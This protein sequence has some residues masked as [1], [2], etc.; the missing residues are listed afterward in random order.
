MFSQTTTSYDPIHS[1]KGFYK[2]EKSELDFRIDK[3]VCFNHH[4]VIANFF[5]NAI[6]TRSLS[7][8]QISHDHSSSKPKGFI[9][10]K[11]TLEDYQDIDNIL[12]AFR[13]WQDRNYFHPKLL[14]AHGFN[15]KGEPI[16]ATWE[17]QNR[18]QS[19]RNIKPLSEAL[20][21]YKGK[22]VFLTLTVD[23]SRS[24]QDAWQ[25][26]AQRWHI[27]M[28]RL[29]LEIRSAP[30]HKDFK[31]SDLHYIWVL[32]A[33]GNGYPHIHALFLGIDWLFWAGNK[34]A[35]IEDNPHSKNLKH[36]WKWGSV[37]INSTKKGENV[38]N[39]V[40]Y[41]MKYIRKTFDPYSGDSKKELTQAMLWC[42]NKRSWNTSR[43][44]FEYLKY[45]KPEP[46]IDMDLIS[47]DN[48]ERL[49]GQSTPYIRLVTETPSPSENSITSYSINDLDYLSTIG[50]PS[51]QESKAIQ[52]LVGMI[53]H[54][55]HEP[56]DE[57]R[58]YIRP[59]SPSWK[60]HRKKRKPGS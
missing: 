52:F 9:E 57:F 58:Y 4:S 3:S 49:D 44:I 33:Q 36:F 53:Q 13:S 41:L 60:L 23:H 48:F 47:M 55:H 17:A 21:N 5:R 12:T 46:E 50:N 39:P 24:L 6:H 38:K 7:P 56:L 15:H 34:Q 27:F 8:D 45:E 22:G 35:W 11:H 37:F 30:G 2:S 26:I 28:R 16:D 31:Q 42:F 19:N 51:Y 25:G 40:N 43:K 18:F 32:E 10:N 1:N 54:H 59:K 20:Y 29:I 14:H